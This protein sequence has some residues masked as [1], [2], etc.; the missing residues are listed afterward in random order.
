MTIVLKAVMLR[1]ADHLRVGQRFRALLSTLI[2][3]WGVNTF[4]RGVNFRPVDLA[5]PESGLD[6]CGLHHFS[7]RSSSCFLPIVRLAIMFHVPSL[8]EGR[9]MK[10]PEDGC[11]QGQVITQRENALFYQGPDT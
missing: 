9:P 5:Y 1:T 8:S 3:E 11:Q 6:K 2:E 7:A 4:E 10:L